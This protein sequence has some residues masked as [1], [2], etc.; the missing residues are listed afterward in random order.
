[1][2]YAREIFTF[3][4]VIIEDTHKI[5]KYENNNAMGGDLIPVR[6]IKVAVDF[7]AEPFGDM[8][9]FSLK[10]NSFSRKKENR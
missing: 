2:R 7:Y 10:E 8:V 9:N 6:L 5:L 1:M 4:K 3:A